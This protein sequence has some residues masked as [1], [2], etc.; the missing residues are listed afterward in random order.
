MAERAIPIT[1]QTWIKRDQCLELLRLSGRHFKRV[2]KQL[3]YRNSNVIGLN[4]KAQREYLLSSLPAAA[5]L[6]YAEMQAA[7]WRGAGAIVRSSGEADSI[8]RDDNRALL[9]AMRVSD[10]A[11]T[12]RGIRSGNIPLEPTGEPTATPSQ[13]SLFAGTGQ[14]ANTPGTGAAAPLAPPSSPSLA[15]SEQDRVALTDEQREQAEARRTA[16]WP[17]LEYRAL[18]KSLRPNLETHY[19]AKVRT[20]EQFAEHLGRQQQP[21]VSARTIWRW[22]RVF[23]ATLK[24]GKNPLYALADRDRKDQGKSRFFEEHPNAAAYII[25]K[26]LDD[27][28]TNTRAV[29]SAL[30]REWEK[31]ERR[32]APPSVPTVRAFLNDH[33]IVS[34]PLRTL[35]LEGPRALW[36]K[37]SLPV[38]RGRRP[39]MDWWVS[40]HRKLDVMCR[41]TLFS[42]EPAGAAFRLWLTAVGDMGSR[43]WVGFAFSPLPSWRTI[44]SAHRMGFSEYGFPQNFYW[45][46]GEDFKKFQRILEGKDLGEEY[47][48]TLAMF[49]EDQGI[50]YRVTRAMAYHPRSKPI[51]SWFA[52]MSK[53]FDILFRE[54]YLGNG[55]GK[56]SEYAD[57]AEKRH[58]KWLA[59]KAPSTQLPSDVEV[60]AAT[61]Q[62]MVNEN[63]RPRKQLGDRTPFQILDEQHP[64]E[65]RRPVSRRLLDSLF[66]ERDI[67]T[68]SAGGRVRLDNRFYEPADGYHGAMDSW[69]GQDVLVLR[70]PYALEEATVVDPTNFR[71]VAELCLQDFV[72]QCPGGHVTRDE[73]QKYMRLQRGQRRGYSNFLAFLGAMSEAQGWKS[74]LDVLTEQA[75]L[76]QTGT[77][78]RALTAQMSAAAPG[79]RHGRGAA[80]QTPRQFDSPFVSDAVARIV[81][82]MNEE[83][84][85]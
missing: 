30:A 28:V 82:V 31:L 55:S 58:K 9:S 66:S 73:I 19:G 79:A 21:A 40:D 1:G 76:I 35:A 10:A 33:R 77:D 74:E 70:D 51:E 75:G 27:K 67:R 22:V 62:W 85:S 54:A 34:A 26:L 57:A 5:Q 11:P 8:V 37:H 71:F 47:G 72:A 81:E 29:H 78:N 14:P 18:P 24:A 45:D 52:G 53:N 20:A 65:S 60:I 50:K 68:V 80:P 69:Q 25:A 2:A 43:A 32:G 83:E 63:N 46:N 44:G 3:E 64:A 61:I 12:E 7:C 56:R 4:G 49:M 6:R 48:K 15:D 36:A 84:P 23:N 13:N 41:N 17:L 16:I 42:T 59:G 38:M 39:A